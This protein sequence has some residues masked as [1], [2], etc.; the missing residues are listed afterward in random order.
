MRLPSSLSVLFLSFHFFLSQE[1]P[2]GK[3]KEKKKKKER[4]EGNLG[5]GGEGEDTVCM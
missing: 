3:G 2:A 4:T 5:G 1:K